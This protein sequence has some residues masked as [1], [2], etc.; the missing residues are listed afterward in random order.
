MRDINIDR[1]ETNASTP[2]LVPFGVSGILAATTE[3]RAK[4]VLWL[5]A[6]IWRNCRSPLY[7]SNL[8]RVAD[9]R[10]IL[11]NAG[12]HLIFTRVRWMDKGG[13]QAASRYPRGIF[14]DNI[15]PTS[16]ISAARFRRWPEN[17]AA[18]QTISDCGTF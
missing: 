13:I 6:S 8:G 16:V 7:R 14:Q 9:P 18:V 2:H 5:E 11:G 10:S 17:A 15:A 12:L 4:F 3:L 1:E